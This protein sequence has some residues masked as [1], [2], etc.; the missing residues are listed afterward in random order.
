MYGT[1]AKYHVKAGH[2]EDVARE[3]DDFQAN[4]PEGWLA[5]SVYRSVDHP[6]EIWIA[7]VFESEDHYKRNAD[8][9]EMDKRFRGM[10]QHLEGEPEW[11]DGHVI[12]H[13]T[14][15]GAAV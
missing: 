10:L 11:H 7:A 12:R 3:F 15:A 13:T 8:S 4:P 9:P 1:I 6:D 5:T 14:K 2:Y